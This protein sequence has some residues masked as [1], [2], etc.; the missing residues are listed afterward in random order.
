MTTKDYEV[1]ILTYKKNEKI[2]YYYNT[3]IDEINI[4]ID[5]NMLLNEINIYK[6]QLFYIPHNQV[7]SLKFLE[8]CKILCI[9][10]PSKIGDKICL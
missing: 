3:Y 10:I 4:L 1:D 7:I 5:G 9:K 6:D 8:D 2:D